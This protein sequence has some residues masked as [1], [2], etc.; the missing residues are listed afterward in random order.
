MNK[1]LVASDAADGPR[2]PPG[3]RRRAVQGLHRRRH[4]ERQ[5]LH[6][7]DGPRLGAA[8]S[9]M[10]GRRPADRLR[11]AA[12][13]AH[14][15]QPPRPG[16]GAGRDHRRP[17]RQGQTSPRS[18]RRPTYRARCARRASSRRPTSRRRRRS[19]APAARPTTPTTTSST[20]RARRGRTPV[21]LT[22]AGCRTS[23]TRT[24][25]RSRRSRR[26]ERMAG[27]V[28]LTLSIATRRRA[29][30]A[31]TAGNDFAKPK[32][33]QVS[34]TS[35]TRRSRPLRR[36]RRSRR[37]GPR[38][39][40]SLQ[41]DAQRRPRASAP[42]I[43]QVPAPTAL[44]DWTLDVISYQQGA[45]AQRHRTGADG[46]VHPH[47]RR[48][49][50]AARLAPDHRPGQPGGHRDLH[51]LSRRRAGVDRRHRRLPRSRQRSRTA[52]TP[53][54]STASRCPYPDQIDPSRIDI[55][56][57]AQTRRQ[58][59]RP[60]RVATLLGNA[61]G[62][63]LTQGLV[64]PVRVVPYGQAAVYSSTAQGGTVG[65]TV[66]ATLSLTLGAP[67]SFGRVHAGRRPAPTA[68]ARRPP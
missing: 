21:T 8:A 40:G 68:S 38:A 9:P 4:P 60:C 58:P 54:P 18:P 32:Q 51:D 47:R 44:R 49:R 20:T 14:A 39:P 66:P 65:G 59:D 42:S 31:L 30:V 22:G 13:D 55:G 35:T 19:S 64:G 34:A 56:A 24:P 16:R 7:H 5:Q 46:P 23:S 10:G 28:K 48:Q 25:A 6:G 50:H 61:R 43:A 12:A 37:S 45:D 33:Q 36:G 63:T 62:Q 67:A 53:S 11:R 29:I 52:T 26:I 41:H 15:G 3:P 27:G 2:R 17:A 1:T 57:A